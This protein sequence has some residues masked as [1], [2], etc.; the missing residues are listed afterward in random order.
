[1][2]NIVN[3]IKKNPVAK[4][5]TAVVIGAAS[6]IVTKLYLNDELYL[7]DETKKAAKDI[8][9]GVAKDM[10]NNTIETTVNA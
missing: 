1:M 7:S 4:N 8:T 10:N 5:V 2:D 9:I 3:V 6:F